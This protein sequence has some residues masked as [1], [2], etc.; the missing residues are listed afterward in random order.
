M[1]VSPNLA[2]FLVA[3]ALTGSAG[4]M[5]LT[6]AAYAYIAVYAEDRARDLI[7]TLMLVTGLAGSG[8]LPPSSRTWLAGAASFSSMPRSWS[9]LPVRWFGL[10]CPSPGPRLLRPA[11]K[12]AG[13]RS[14]PS[15]CWWPRLHS[16]AL[17]PSASTLWEFNFCRRWE[18]TSPAPSV[19]PA[20]EESNGR[21]KA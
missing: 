21:A 7:G 9:W 15:S 4:A 3:W 2:V 16:T 17:S 12:S 10:G 19:V 20:R 8:P 11:V 5:F 13:T 14:A 6:T 1:A 18:W